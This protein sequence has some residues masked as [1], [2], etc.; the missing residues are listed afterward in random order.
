MAQEIFWL[1]KAHHSMY[2]FT[3]FQSLPFWWLFSF[4]LFWSTLTKYFLV[5]LS[6]ILFLL[7]ST[8][9]RVLHS[10]I[11]FYQ[12]FIISSLNAR[13]AKIALSSH[14]GLCCLA[15]QDKRSSVFCL[16]LPGLLRQCFP[17][18][19]CPGHEVPCQNGEQSNLFRNFLW[20]GYS[21]VLRRI[22]SEKH[23]ALNLVFKTR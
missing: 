20:W 4:S 14:L 1:E 16:Y 19:L 15:S 5:Y 13:A 2:N 6:A 18:S 17:S 3:Y 11:F 10:F 8:S 23:L 22:L 9:I 7:W 12:E 21:V